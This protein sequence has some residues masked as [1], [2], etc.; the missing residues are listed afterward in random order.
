MFSSNLL[1]FTKKAIFMR[2]YVIGEPIL[3]ILKETYDLF[4]TPGSKEGLSSSIILGYNLGIN[5]NISEEKKNAT[6]IAFEFITS[7]DTQKKCVMKKMCITGISSL[8]YDDDICKDSDCELFRQIQPVGEPS[9]I[10][11][12]TDEYKRKFR[13]YIYQYLYKN[14]TIDKILERIDD[15]TKDYYISKDSNIG[16]ISFIIILVISILMFLSLVFLF[17]ENF[18][19]FFSYLSEDLWI[20][21]IIGTIIIA[22]APLSIFGEI[23]SLKCHLKI[24]LLAIGFTFISSPILYKLIIQFPE[25]NK[26]SIWVNK[27][28]YLFIISTLLIDILLYSLSLI[29]P[30]TTKEIIINEGKNFTVCQYNAIYSIILLIVYK[31]ITIAIILL[32][33]FIVW[34]I[35]ATFYD[36]RFIY[37]AFSINIL[38]LIII[39]IFYI[40]QINDYKVYFLIHECLFLLVSISNYIIL[41]GIR[42]ILGFL[43]KQNLKMQFVSDINKNFINNESK[44]ATIDYNPSMYQ[45]SMYENNEDGDVSVSQSQ[46]QKNIFSK[47]IDYHYSTESYIVTNKTALS[48]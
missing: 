24:L 44:N 12:Q 21:L 26:I 4:P 35:S 30:Y 37:G 1:F 11:N 38:S 40:I 2:Y 8:W 22:M 9:Y 47:I 27:H 3:S 7:K 39:I 15:L 34:N 41:Y 19:P 18:Q 20:I 16:L 14:E 46:V 43:H 23:T 32:F 6:I 13:K 17:I 48:N 28:K 29:N 10:L 36:T 25:V 33:T 31:F 45:S 42:L 5:K